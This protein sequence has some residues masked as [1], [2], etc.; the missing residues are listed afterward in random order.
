MKPTRM[1]MAR[2]AVSAAA[3]GALMVSGTS[4]NDH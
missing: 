2:G 3:L 4:S 1:G